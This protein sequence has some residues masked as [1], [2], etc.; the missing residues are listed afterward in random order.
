MRTCLLLICLVLF[1]AL[2]AKAQASGPESHA[3]T[4]AELGY[5][6]LAEAV[7]AQDAFRFQAQGMLAGNGIDLLSS[8]LA[9]RWTRD[10]KTVYRMP[11]E[12]DAPLLV[13]TIDRA[14]IDMARN[15]RRHIDRTV[16]LDLTWWLSAEDG[17]L[18]DTQ[19]CSKSRDDG[20][21]REQAR[22]LA[23]PRSPVTNPDLPPRSR[24]KQALEPVVLI[25]ATA[26]GTYLLFNLRSRRADNG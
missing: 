1:S 16:A 25:G 12:Q 9:A 24:F 18:I 22:S 3:E 21:T 17:A 14:D 6:C 4:L 2:Q 7:S 23:D 10:G 26:V 5:A 11:S 15:G 13:V 20:L 8:P 19:S